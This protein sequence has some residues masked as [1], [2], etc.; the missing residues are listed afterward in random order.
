MNA[1]ASK[2]FWREA[3]TNVHRKHSSA[4]ICFYYRMRVKHCSL[5]GFKLK[6]SSF[7]ENMD[8]FVIADVVQ[9]VVHSFVRHKSASLIF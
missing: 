9:P 4:C 1:L 6:L 5:R 7:P 3:E 2:D 8:I